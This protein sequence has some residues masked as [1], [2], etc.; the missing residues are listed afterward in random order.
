MGK[1]GWTELLLLVGILLL[2]F[3]ATKL[4]AVG[5]GLGEGI[6]EFKKTFRDDEADSTAEAS[7]AED[8]KS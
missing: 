8:K 3:G 2:L 5:R 7:S 6:R 4:P 1:I